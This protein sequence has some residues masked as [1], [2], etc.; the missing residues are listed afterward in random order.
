MDEAPLRHAYM[1][2]THGNFPILERQLSFL[3]SENADFFIHVDAN[4]RNFDFEKYRRIPRIS[5]VTFVDRLHISWGH[6]SLT[7]CELRLLRAAAPG[8]YDYYHLL[9]GVDVPVK[10]REYIEGYF[11]RQSGVNYINLERAQISR[12]HLDRVRYYY[13]F[14]KWN[15][16]N[17]F[18]RR[19]IR[20][21][22][23]LAQRLAL[24]DRTKKAPQGFVFQ[25]ATEWFS[26]T[27]ALAQYV[28]S[29]EALIREL[30]ADT[31]C[32]DEMFLPSV[33]MSSPFRDTVPPADPRGK[34]KNCCRYIDWERGSPYTFTDADYD[35]LISTGPDYLFA[36]KFD[37]AAAPDLVDRLFEHF[38]ADPR[39]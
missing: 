27:D 13:P 35:E 15:V 21:L 2:I 26:I 24:V 31:F 20:E 6:Y 17:V 23:V 14:Q 9:S 10:T 19:S 11:R 29:K 39:E 3:D 18:L 16:R 1:I 30:F 8:H 7:E 5:G 22:T 37:Y 25:K 34:H 12:R 36:R 33:A 4:V 38:G 28:L 32:S